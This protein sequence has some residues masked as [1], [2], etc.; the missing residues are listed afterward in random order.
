VGVTFGACVDAS[1]FTALTFDLWGDVGPTGSLTVYASTR[2]N[3]PAPPFTETGTCRPADPAEPY[4]SCLDPYAQISVSEGRAPVRLNF[5]SFMGG[6]PHDSVDAGELLAFF[7]SFDWNQSQA[8]YTV[9]VSM[10]DVQF[11]D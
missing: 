8:A 11:V 2:R 6:I 3:S 10:S 7:F 5:S 9:D 4:R 1:R